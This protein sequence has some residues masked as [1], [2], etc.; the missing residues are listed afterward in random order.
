MTHTGSAPSPS[1]RLR[2]GSGSGCGPPTTCLDTMSM[3]VPYFSGQSKF[4]EA[5]CCLSVFLLSDLCSYWKIW[6]LTLC[7]P[8]QPPQAHILIIQMISSWRD[9]HSLV[10]ATTM[11][12]SKDRRVKFGGGLR[13]GL[14]LPWEQECWAADTHTETEVREKAEDR[15]A[16]RTSA[17][18]YSCHVQEGDIEAEGGKNTCTSV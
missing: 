6:I 12:T 15:R 9:D 14:W 16:D 8:P 11:C 7:W 18:C 3:N 13:R 4:H 2:T 1:I 10:A 5:V 17:I